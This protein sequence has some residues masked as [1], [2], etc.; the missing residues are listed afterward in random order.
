[1]ETQNVALFPLFRMHPRRE[2]VKALGDFSSSVELLLRHVMQYQSERHAESNEQGKA[3]L[4]ALLLSESA[5][6]QAGEQAIDAVKRHERIQQLRSEETRLSASISSFAHSLDAVEQQLADACNREFLFLPG[7]P[8]RNART[9]AVN[10]DAAGRGGALFSSDAAALVAALAQVHKRRRVRTATIPPVS[11]SSSSSYPSA[12]AVGV[13]SACTSSS[14]SLSSSS[15]ASLSSPSSS[16]SSSSSSSVVAET[17][18]RNPEVYG[19]RRLISVQDVLLYAERLALKSEAP[20][21]KRAF[22]LLSIYRASAMFVHTL[23]FSSSQSR[24]FSPGGCTHFLH[25]L[26]SQQ[27][28][29]AGD[30]LE[31]LHQPSILSQ[32]RFDAYE[33]NMQMSKL[34]LPIDRLVAECR[35]SAPDTTT[36]TRGAAAAATSAAAAAAEGAA[37]TQ[38]AA[39]ATAAVA[40]APVSTT[41]P[42]PAPAAASAAAQSTVPAAAVESRHQHE[43]V[44]DHPPSEKKK[45]Q[46]MGLRLLDSDSDEDLSD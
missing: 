31:R 38:A 44:P 40:G 6:Q 17:E 45:K 21:T 24:F 29:N 10:E 41:A 39:A 11:A 3:L 33:H 36:S 22:L 15:S 42:A 27:N 9:D 37:H 25:V 23:L 12:T 4:R 18:H 46:S 1:M 14:S 30:M 28:S 35:A 32:P 5:L 2:G 7:S 20:G 26:H 8:T 16:S 43:H 34:A 13:S 19:N